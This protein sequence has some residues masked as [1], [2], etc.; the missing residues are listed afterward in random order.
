MPSSAYINDCSKI[1]MIWLNIFFDKDSQNV[2]NLT[3][4]Y[5]NCYN[6]NEHYILEIFVKNEHNPTASC[7]L[8]VLTYQNEIKYY[9]AVLILK[10]NLNIDPTIYNNQKDDTCL[11]YLAKLKLM[12]LIDIITDS[13]LFDLIKDNNAIEFVLM[14]EILYEQK[15]IPRQQRVILA[16]NTQ[17]RSKYSVKIEKNKFDT[18]VLEPNC[19][20]IYQGLRDESI[21]HVSLK[22][23]LEDI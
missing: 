7:L 15:R 11:Y 17:Y 1:N 13:E 19:R 4:K 20:K 12:K 10:T 3:E 23:F 9:Q 14:K 6:L 16:N 21:Y 2:C 8:A 18:F 5:L 22:I